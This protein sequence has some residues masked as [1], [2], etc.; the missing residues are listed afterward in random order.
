MART[1]GSFATALDAVTLA[2]PQNVPDKEKD[3]TVFIGQSGTNTDNA[4]V[5]EGRLAGGTVYYPIPALVLGTS[6]PTLGTTITPG[7]NGTSAYLVWAAGCD[8]VRARNTVLTTGSATVEINSNRM[9][10]VPPF[11][12]GVAKALS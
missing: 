11:N 9:F 4:F 1:T 7:T 10:E 3:T 8:S 6:Q 2:I 12:T 5:I